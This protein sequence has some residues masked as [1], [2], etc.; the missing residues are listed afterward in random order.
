M[1]RHK[2]NEPVFSKSF[3]ELANYLVEKRQLNNSNLM[4]SCQKSDLSRF[5]FQDFSNIQA[6]D[7]IY[8]PKG[9]NDSI[10]TGKDGPGLKTG[11]SN[12][13][14]PSQL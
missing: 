14:P 12:N 10:L 1:E 7:S 5:S 4:K 8:M 11:P 2:L 3:S 6:H 9:L 13:A